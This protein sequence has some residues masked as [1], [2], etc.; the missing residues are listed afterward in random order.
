DSDGDGR[1]RAM[2]L[3][4]AIKWAGAHLKNADDL[5]NPPDA[6]PFAAIDDANPEGAQMLA[7]AQHVLELLGKRGADSLSVADTADARARFAQM[8]FN[9]DGIVTHDAA[10][11]NEAVQALLDD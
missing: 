1:I 11:G 8:P 5:V 7:V 2:E 4:A 6:L 9:G 10:G 3:I